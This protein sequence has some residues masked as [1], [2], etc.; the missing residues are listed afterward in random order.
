[1]Q[2]DTKHLNSSVAKKKHIHCGS[3]L[4]FFLLSEEVTGSALAAKLTEAIK[5][6]C[7]QEDIQAMLKEVSDEEQD[8]QFN[9]LR[10][11]T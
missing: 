3:N 7:S 11:R 9:S 5:T 10:V 2:L 8:Q 1:L 6:K 4:T